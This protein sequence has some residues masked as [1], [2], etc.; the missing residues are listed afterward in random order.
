MERVFQE[1]ELGCRKDGAR[2]EFG[3]SETLG[4]LKGSKYTWFLEYKGWGGVRL[5]NEAEEAKQGIQEGPP[6][7]DK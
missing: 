6:G 7:P 2:K 1:S 4:E 5:Q 3:A